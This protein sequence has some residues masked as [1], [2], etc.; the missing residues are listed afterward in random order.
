MDCEYLLFPQIP[1]SHIVF[2]CI[3]FYFVLH[4]YLVFVHPLSNVASLVESFNLYRSLFSTCVRIFN[5]LFIF[6]WKRE[7][8][9]V[10]GY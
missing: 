4:D 7:A 3:L 10:I 1:I 2:N 9:I 5:I 6:R 8:R